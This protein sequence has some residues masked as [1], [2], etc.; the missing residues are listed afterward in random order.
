LQIPPND[1]SEHVL[2]AT[3]IEGAKAD[4][5]KV[6]ITARTTRKEFDAFIIYNPSYF[7]SKLFPR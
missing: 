4:T 6:A 1:R 5:E 2:P 3:D 7:P